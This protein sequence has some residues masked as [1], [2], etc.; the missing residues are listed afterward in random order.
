MSATDATSTEH[1]EPE[2]HEEHPAHPSDWVYV[3]VALI[4][5]ALTAVEVFSYFH[6]VLDWGRVLMPALIVLMVVKFY[7]IAAYFMHLKFD[8]KVLR[9]AF[10]AGII[11][12]LS[13][14]LIALMTFR[15]FGDWA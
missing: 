11:L 13:V 6:S 2:A 5:A 15:F 12:A 4:L 8:Q 3:R 14:Y 9:R 1:A 7:L 10:T